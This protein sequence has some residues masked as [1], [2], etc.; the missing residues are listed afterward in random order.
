[1]HAD[2]VE[3]LAALGI[4]HPARVVTGRQDAAELGQVEGSAEEIMACLIATGYQPSPGG[5]GA[6]APFSRS[7]RSPSRRA[8][9]RRSRP[10]SPG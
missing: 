3:P 1:M 6:S 4:D 10:D 7:R 2:P 5:R 9:G 8:A